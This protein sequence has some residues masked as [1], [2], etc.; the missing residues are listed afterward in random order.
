MIKTGMKGNQMKKMQLT[1]VIGI[2]CAMM[3]IGT[4][5]AQDQQQGGMRQPGMG[6]G[7]QNFTPEQMAQ[8]R[9]QM[10]KSMDP[11]MVFQPL[12]QQTLER[13]APTIGL[14]AAQEA[15]ADQMFTDLAKKVQEIRGKTDYNQTLLDEMKS[16]NPD[17][18]RVGAIVDALLK[19]QNDIL[20]AE[21][22]TWI[23]FEKLLT[24]DQ[25][26]AL[27]NMMPVQMGMM[28]QGM[29]RPAGARGNNQKRQGQG[30]RNKT[31]QTDQNGQQD[32]Q[33]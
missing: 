1:V 5:Y 15:S 11:V 12:T 29:N 9:Q 7:M 10:L 22:Q 24:S 26:T 4:L 21:L 14:T 16:Q 33:Q 19:Q 3:A 28:R 17:P 31:D 25:R 20:K 18:Q 27:W 30:M 13:I 6:Y 32:I 23:G 2:L 8:M